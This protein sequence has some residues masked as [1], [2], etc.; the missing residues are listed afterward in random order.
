M[1]NDSTINDLTVD[2]S[3]RLAFAANGNNVKIWDLKK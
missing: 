3:G 1:S 2:H